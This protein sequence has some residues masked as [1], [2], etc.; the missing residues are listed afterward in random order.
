M[1]TTERARAKLGKA[2]PEVVK[3]SEPL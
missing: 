1:F 2:Y 3:E